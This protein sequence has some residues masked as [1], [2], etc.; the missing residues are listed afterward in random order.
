MA[1]EQFDDGFATDFAV[2]QCDSWLTLEETRDRWRDA[3]AIEDDALQDYLDVAAQQVLAYGPSRIAETIAATGCV[4]THYRVAQLMQT[5][6]LW[7]AIK[8]DPSSNYQGAEPGFTFTPFPLD[9]T[10]KAVIRPKTAVP[11]AR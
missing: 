11:V 1:D 10:V 7:N 8:T 4:P 9:W 6:N 2:G 5:R 3:N